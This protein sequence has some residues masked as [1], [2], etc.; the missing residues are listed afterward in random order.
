MRQ[1]NVSLEGTGF[2]CD[3][4]YLIQTL[5]SKC[6]PEEPPGPTNKAIN[7]ENSLYQNTV[8]HAFAT[9]VFTNIKYMVLYP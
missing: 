5:F 7:K 6:A 9:E 4:Y 1:V 8:D 2:I 3:F